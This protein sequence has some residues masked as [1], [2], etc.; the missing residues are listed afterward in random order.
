[1][2]L[3]LVLLEITAPPVTVT[4]LLPLTRTA[5][6]TPVSRATMPRP[7]PELNLDPTGD[8][9]AAHVGGPGLPDA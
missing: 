3:A 1:M 4:V 9:G 7:T 2:A 5:Q 6:S 8:G